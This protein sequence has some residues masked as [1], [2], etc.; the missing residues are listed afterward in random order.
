ML[1]TRRNA[2]LASLAQL[3]S[4]IA[5]AAALTSAT[6]CKVTDSDNILT[7]GMYASMYASADGS[8]TTLVSASLYLGPPTDLIFIDLEGGDELLAHHAGQ[9]KSMSEQII[10][11][12]VTHTASFPDDA[13]DAQFDVEFRRDVDDGAPSTVLTL[14]APFT[15]GGVPPSVSRGAAFGVNWTGSAMDRMRWT[16]EGQCIQT[17]SGTINA[18]GTGDPASVTMAAGTFVK[19]PGASVPD[20]CQVK[21]TVV[22]ERDGRVDRGFGEGGTATGAQTRSVM[23]TS[24]P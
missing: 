14:P 5:A 17:A 15:L 19:A 10:L 6:A 3:R 16:A 13:A 18:V 22:R 20:T 9:T 24:T 7:S 21:V 8:G 4:L 23:F 12:I 2:P 1:A 11:N